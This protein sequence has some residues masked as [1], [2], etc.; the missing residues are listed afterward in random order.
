MSLHALVRHFV[1]FRLYQTLVPGW[2]DTWKAW[3]V[4]TNEVGEEDVGEAVHCVPT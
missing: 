1:V 4:V 2:V 3:D